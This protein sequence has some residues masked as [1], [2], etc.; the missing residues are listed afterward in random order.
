MAFGLGHA[1]HGGWHSIGAAF[2]VALPKK[3]LKTEDFGATW[4]DLFGS[5]SC[6]NNK[7]II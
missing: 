7:G 5:G 2:A 3:I 6:P 4:T 1:S